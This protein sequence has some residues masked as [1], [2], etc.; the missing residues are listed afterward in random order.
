M[1]ADVQNSWQSF[2]LS[3]LLKHCHGTYLLVQVSIVLFKYRLLTPVCLCFSIST[4]YD[5]SATPV[6]CPIHCA[7]CHSVQCCFFPVIS[8]GSIDGCSCL[9][10]FEWSHRGLCTGLVNRTNSTN[11]A[12]NKF[13]FSTTAPDTLSDHWSQPRQ[14]RHRLAVNHVSNKNHGVQKWLSQASYVQQADRRLVAYV[15]NTKGSFFYPSQVRLLGPET[16]VRN[17]LLALLHTV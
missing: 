2:F 4:Y 16:V 6:K 3:K 1:Y 10:H 7:I 17:W 5:A 9:I 8:G 15:L 13:Y 12:E 11:V 14:R